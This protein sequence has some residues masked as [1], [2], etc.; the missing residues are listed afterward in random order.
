MFKG[1]KLS[2]IK[3]DNG[4]LELNFNSIEGSVNN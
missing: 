3:I 1:E 4:F 2:L